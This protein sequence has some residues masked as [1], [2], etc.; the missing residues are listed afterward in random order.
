MVIWKS[1]MT[2]KQLI[3]QNQTLTE[4]IERLQKVKG[5]SESLS[6]LP[7]ACL[8]N[9][10]SA[11]EIKLAKESALHSALDD[12]RGKDYD[13]LVKDIEDIQNKSKRAYVRLYEKVGEDVGSHFLDRLDYLASKPSEADK[14]ISGS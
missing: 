14:L 10:N 1:E 6:R 7:S 5:I 12:V 9:M 3:S 11:E 2:Q 8:E 4:E 13:K